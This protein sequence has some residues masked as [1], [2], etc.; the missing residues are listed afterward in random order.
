MRRAVPPDVSSNWTRA[1]RF[2]PARPAR[3]RWLI[4][5]ADALFGPRMGN[6]PGGL[7]A[8]N[9]TSAR[10]APFADDP[11]AR[12]R[13]L[14][15]EPCPPTGRGEWSGGAAGRAA[16][17]TEATLLRGA[18]FGATAALAESP[19]AA[20]VAQLRSVIDRVAAALSQASRES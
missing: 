20:R 17:E 1:G 11:G 16:G 7:G 18:L 8:R 2:G 10:A 4:A 5:G 3:P 6:G 13:A 9:L 14:L 12:W 15:G 19:E